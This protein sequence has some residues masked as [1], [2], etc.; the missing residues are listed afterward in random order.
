MQPHRSAGQPA[1]WHPSSVVAMGAA[2]GMGDDFNNERVTLWTF[3]DGSS[4]ALATPLG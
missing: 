3:S 1:R 2:P 4:Y